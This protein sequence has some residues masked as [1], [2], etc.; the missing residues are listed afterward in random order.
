M[1]RLVL[2]AALVVV[3]ATTASAQMIGATNNYTTPRTD[4]FS[5]TMRPTGGS[6][7]FSAGYP[8]LFTVS[9]SHYLK[10]YFMVGGG[11]GLGYQSGYRYRYR[12][13]YTAG[14]SYYTYYENS[15]SDEY[16]ENHTAVPLFLEMDLRT[17]KYKWSL[18]LNLKMGLNLFGGD[19]RKYS[20]STW[21]TDAY[22]NTVY[23]N[24]E[25]HYYVFFIAAAAGISYQNI[26]LGMGIASGYKVRPN[27]FLSYNLPISTLDRWLFK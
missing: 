26:N 17:P 16:K 5:P 27:F 10:P 25:D 14:S 21:I 22:G 15:W 2:I 18:F 20:E 8:G 9:Y 7:R 19:S 13:G 3:F 4:S 24:Y 11:A 1:K 23:E 12:P 6:L